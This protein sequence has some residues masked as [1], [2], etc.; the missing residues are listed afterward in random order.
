MLEGEGSIAITTGARRRC[1]GGWSLRLCTSLFSSPCPAR[2]PDLI[3]PGRIKCLRIYPEELVLLTGPFPHLRWIDCGEEY[4]EDVKVHSLLWSRFPSLLQSRPV[5]FDWRLSSAI[6]DPPPIQV[7]DI[8]TDKKGTW[9]K[10]LSL[11]EKTLVNLQISA[12][13]GDDWRMVTQSLDFPLLKYL[14]F[15]PSINFSPWSIKAKRHNYAR[16][17]YTNRFRPQWLSQ[18]T[19]AGSLTLISGTPSISRYI[20]WPVIF[21]YDFLQT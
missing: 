19:L 12:H 2:A 16:T 5:T 4:G 14:N 17:S 21:G 10:I 8:G 1:F 15:I 18:S 3:I 13:S 7:L 11:L 20:L 6:I 9:L